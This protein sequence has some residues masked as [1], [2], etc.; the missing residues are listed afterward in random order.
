MTRTLKRDVRMLALLAVL[1]GLVGS[2][3]FGAETSSQPLG[4]DRRIEV[5][6][7]GD[8]IPRQNEPIIVYLIRGNEVV[9]RPRLSVTPVTPQSIVDA[10]AS[11]LTEYERANDLRSS[12]SISPLVFEASRLAGDMAEISVSSTFLAVAGNEQKM[13]LAQVVLSLFKNLDITAVR[14]L[15]GDEPVA[16]PGASGEVIERPL[17]V[18]DYSALIGSIT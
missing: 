17:V 13:L 1:L 8:G 4:D 14:V 15:D 10:L 3:T 6:G 7:A 12:L 16:V 2:C 9:S 5:G 11:E 18:S